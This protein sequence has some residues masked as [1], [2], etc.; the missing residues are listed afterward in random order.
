MDIKDFLKDPIHKSISETLNEKVLSNKYTDTAASTINTWINDGLMDNLRDGSRK[1]RR[2]SV[3]EAIWISIVIELRDFGFRKEAIKVTKDELLP[4]AEEFDTPYPYLEYH[5]ITTILYK[6][7]YFIVIDKDGHANIL[8]YETYVNMLSIED[9]PTSHV[10]ISLGGLYGKLLNKI[11][12]MKADF[13]QFFKLTNE[14]LEL[15]SFI[16]QNDFQTIKIARRNGEIDR[17]EGVERIDREKR[18]IDILN[19]GDYQNIELKQE[20]GKIVCIHR[21]IKKKIS[22]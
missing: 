11:D 7:P 15:L 3:I 16:K 14:E 22:K 19:E 18:I 5:L 1:W 13:T 9:V 8:G 20:D 12:R 10:V 17:L 21:T 6:K 2:F 4:S